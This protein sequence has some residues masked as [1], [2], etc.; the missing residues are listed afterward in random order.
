MLCLA[1]SARDGGRCVAGIV[2]GSGW[3]RPVPRGGGAVP[4]DVAFGFRAGDIVTF[5]LGQRVE[6]APPEDR[7]LRSDFTW[8]RS[9]TEDELAVAM[10][11]YGDA[12][13]DLFG[14]ASHRLTPAE[15][16]ALDHTLALRVPSSLTVERR[17][18]GNVRATFE[19]RGT[20]WDL[21]MRSDDHAAEKARI[22]A[23]LLVCSVGASPWPQTGYHYT[24]A[25]AVLKLPGTVGW[26]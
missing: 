19:L 20:S 2:A 7:E 3:V 1:N 12:S 10:R 24:I 6:G 16:A 23:P 25:V 5:D 21:P 26:Q 18:D 22:E 8:R 9:A 15:F 4:S 13:P 14:T 11:G 17:E